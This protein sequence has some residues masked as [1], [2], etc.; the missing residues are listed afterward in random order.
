[1]G[2]KSKRRGT[3]GTNTANRRAVNGS[4]VLKDALRSCSTERFKEVCKDLAEIVSL[5]IGEDYDPD[6]EDRETVEEKLVEN[7]PVQRLS[8]PYRTTTMRQLKAV[9]GMRI[10]AVP[11]KG[12]VKSYMY[13]T[14]FADLKGGK[15]L[16]MQ[17][18]HRTAMP[19]SVFNHLFK[20]H[21]EGHPVLDGHSANC[22]NILYMIKAPD[23]NEG[24][25]LFVVAF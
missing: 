22:G 19:K 1:M 7:I 24:E 13:S 8:P 5:V 6:T 9:G 14:G 21:K 20:R 17:W 2:K 23:E 4:L 18:T 25:F 15:E 10:T 11:Q 12:S 16:L 3:N